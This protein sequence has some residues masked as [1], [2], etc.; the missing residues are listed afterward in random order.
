MGMYNE[1]KQHFTMNKP[2]F[3][4]F[5][6]LAS[7][8]KP[9]FQNWSVSMMFVGWTTVHVPNWTRPNRDFHRIVR[10]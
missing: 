5:V 3:Q 1:I 10:V 8:G 9:E 6:S 2:E 7:K 4:K